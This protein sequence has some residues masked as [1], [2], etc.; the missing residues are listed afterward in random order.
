MMERLYLNKACEATT[1]AVLVTNVAGWA[2]ALANAWGN[3][4]HGNQVTT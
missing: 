4:W 3:G 1:F 2:S